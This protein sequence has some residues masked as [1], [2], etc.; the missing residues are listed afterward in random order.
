LQLLVLAPGAAANAVLHGPTFT[1]SIARLRLVY[2]YLVI[3]GPSI[4]ASADA[5]I[6]QDSVD[7]VVL[8]ARS[9]S[10]R[11]R[12]LQ[13]ALNQ[14]SADLVAGLVLMDSPV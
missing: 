11:N 8:V 5:S 2:D 6:I 14:L 7:A 9:G 3:D 10:A 12:D 4:L 13:H 1:A